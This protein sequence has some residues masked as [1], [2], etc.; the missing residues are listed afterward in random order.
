[1]WPVQQ[2]GY[3]KGYKKKK[4]GIGRSRVE[5]TW[6]P[7]AMIKTSTRE[8]KREKTPKKTPNAMGGLCQM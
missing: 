8:S 7:D 3:S 5:E 4:I 2:A 6:K 1:M